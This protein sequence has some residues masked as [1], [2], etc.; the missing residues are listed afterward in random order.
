MLGAGSD[1]GSAHL[2]VLWNPDGSAVRIGDGTRNL[3]S[4]GELENRKSNFM[5]SV[6]VCLRRGGCEWTLHE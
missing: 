4:I 1:I 2:K 3:T 5:C 6:L